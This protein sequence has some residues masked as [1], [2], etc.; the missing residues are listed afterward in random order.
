MPS[1]TIFTAILVQ[2]PTNKKLHCADRATEMSL[3]SLP[4]DCLRLV[5]IHVN[6]GCEKQIAWALSGTCRS[7]RQAVKKCPASVKLQGKWTMR[8][9]LGAKLLPSATHAMGTPLF[10]PEFLFDP[11]QIQ[12]R[13]MAHYGIPVLWNSS[14]SLC[15]KHSPA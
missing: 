15:N 9:L 12:R 8:Q 6:Y 4:L 10:R 5:L 2:Q 13:A 1:L 14:P 7:I 3:C 11:M